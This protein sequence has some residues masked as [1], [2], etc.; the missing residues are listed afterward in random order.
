MASTRFRQAL[1]GLDSLNSDKKKSLSSGK[2]ISA[3]LTPPLLS[4]HSL[5]SKQTG[6]P[7]VRAASSQERLSKRI[8]NINPPI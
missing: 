5:C 3:R 1:L 6:S 4:S 2:T 7:V 8:E